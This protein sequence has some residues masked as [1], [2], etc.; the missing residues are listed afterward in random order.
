MKIEAKIKKD[1]LNFSTSE[2]NYLSLTTSF[3]APKLDKAFVASKGINTLLASPFAISCK[4]SN[5]F[6]W[7]NLSSGLDFLIDS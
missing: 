6:N 4:A 7:I 2:M 5:D 1:V 3:K